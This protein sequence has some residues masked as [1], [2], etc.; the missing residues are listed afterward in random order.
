MTTLEELKKRFDDAV[1]AREQARK[2]LTE[3][4]EGNYLK[5]K[6]AVN[7]AYRELMNARYEAGQGMLD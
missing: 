1:E 3:E 4:S 2:N 6:Q 7:D 5:L